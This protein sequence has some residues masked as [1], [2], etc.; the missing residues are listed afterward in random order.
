MALSRE[1]AIEIGRV[2]A[3]EVIAR[4][5]GIPELAFHIAEH[6]VTGHAIEVNPAKARDLNVPAKCF[7]YGGEEYCWK[8][9]YVG[10]ISSKKNPEQ[11]ATIKVKEA[12]APGAQERFARLK[13]AV[14][15]AHAKWGKEGGG[16]E[17][18]WKAVGET[19]AEKG[20]EL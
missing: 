9:G 14:G 8:P 1:E 11:Y 15:K 5:Y 18:W 2:I 12:A 19:L 6:E 10:L 16:L 4:V 13:S 7:P 17:G 3:D 20:L